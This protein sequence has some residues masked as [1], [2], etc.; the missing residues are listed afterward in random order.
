MIDSQHNNENKL[1]FKFHHFSSSHEL[2]FHDF[3]DA[4][5]DSNELVFI[6]NQ[7][8]VYSYIFGLVDRSRV[9][10]PLHVLAV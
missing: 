2:L 4:A 5:L 8:F 7:L 3:S 9:Q 6:G 10:D 1:D